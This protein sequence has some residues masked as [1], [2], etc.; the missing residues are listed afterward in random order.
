[1][2]R[3]SGRDLEQGQI[4]VA[5]DNL[6]DHDP[7]GPV[8]YGSSGEDPGAGSGGQAWHV[9]SPGKGDG[10]DGKSGRQCREVGVAHGIAIHGRYR[11]ARGIAAR[12][13]IGGQHPLSGGFQ[14]HRLAREGASLVQDQGEGGIEINHDA[15][16]SPDRPPDLDNSR[17]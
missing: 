1:M 15:V 4:A 9:C 12:L 11:S 5:A 16:Q 17:T 8:G 2:G 3:R 7:V 6:L 10:G 14:R 13:Q